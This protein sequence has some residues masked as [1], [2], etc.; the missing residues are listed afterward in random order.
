MVFQNLNEIFA[1]LVKHVPFDINEERKRIEYLQE[2]L[3]HSYDDAKTYANMIE[4]FHEY[5]LDTEF[6]LVMSDLFAA[7]KM[8]MKWKD[9]R[10][11]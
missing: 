10:A 4:E 7:S 9:Y 8:P 5:G 1:E 11:A 3:H 2:G 6:D